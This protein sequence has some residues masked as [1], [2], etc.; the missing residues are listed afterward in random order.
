MLVVLPV[1]AG[2]IPLKFGRQAPRLC[3]PRTCGDDPQ[4]YETHIRELWVL[5]ISGLHQIQLK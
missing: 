3:V 1:H 4:R 2:M 5:D